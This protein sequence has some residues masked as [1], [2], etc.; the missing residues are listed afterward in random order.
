M[1][2]TPK[3][4]PKDTTPWAWI[5]AVNDVLM[6]GPFEEPELPVEVLPWLL[7]SG[8]PE[9]HDKQRL[10]ELGVTH[11]LTTNKMYSI[12]E[13]EKL[14]SS[15]HKCG[16]QHF[17]VE[18]L[19][20]PNYDML[21]HWDASRAF[22]QQVREDEKN[23]VVVHCAAGQNR[24]GLIVGAAL[25]EMER[26]K[27]MDVVKLL[28]AKRR[29]VLINRSFQKQL[30]LLAAKEGLLGDKPAGYTDDAIT[31]DKTDGKCYAVLGGYV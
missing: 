9:L 8:L 1:M 7:L 22:L 27:L 14:K 21:F 20:H 26:M 6:N 10:M 24:S 11:V 31:N 19:D 25:I 12:H 18:G 4:E 17:A 15:L 29:I 30:C 3:E 13:V 28:K 23:K 2:T 16:I 5:K